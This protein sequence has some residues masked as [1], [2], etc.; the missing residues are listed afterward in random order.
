MKTQ[1]I[2]ALLLTVIL[3]G[4]TKAPNPSPA[5]PDTPAEALEIALP[6]PL[7]PIPHPPPTPSKI[8]PPTPSKT[9]AD[10]VYWVL[11]PISVESAD[12]ISTLRPGTAVK[13]IRPGFF[14]TPLGEMHISEDRLSN[15]LIQAR[16]ALAKYNARSVYVMPTHPLATLRQP[17]LTNAT[18]A[19]TPAPR[20]IPAPTQPATSSL[21]ALHTRTKDGWLWQKDARG[22]WERV[23]P[24]GK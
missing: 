22:R 3:S 11:F 20:V 2:R 23:R 7:P 13:L 5:I 10:G 12:G 8:T 4:C 1:L 17:T 18:P 24:L 16:N 19:H 14:V 15:D 6:N 9:V 21:G